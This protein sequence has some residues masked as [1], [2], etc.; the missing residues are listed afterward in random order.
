M[1][2]PPSPAPLKTF[3]AGALS[4]RVYAK[5]SELAED[6]AQIARHHLLQTLAVQETASII[7]ACATSQVQ[8]LEA[9]VTLP[10]LDWL[11]IIVFHM[12][13]YLGLPADHPASFRRFLRERLVSRVKPGTVHYV[14][15]DAL[16][17]LEECDRYTRL[18]QA[19]PIDLCC[20]GI[21]ENGHI[22]FNDPPVA[23][24][25]DPRSLKIVKLDLACRQ[26]QVGE[27]FYPSLDAV[28][29]YALTLTIPALCSARQMLCIV[30]EKRKAQAVRDALHGPISTSCPASIL[31]KQP[32]CTLFLDVD[33]A[34]LLCA[35]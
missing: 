7:F 21:G 24:S 12:D 11:R 2:Q 30:P 35:G 15:G 5:Q 27:G 17:P 9:L 1:P 23:D 29:Q 26:Q 25:A 18:L 8:F 10:G 14:E 19:Q 4:V 31:R 32:H 28:P 16:Q 3:Q 13:E 6:A 22:A 33:S 34:S 20:L